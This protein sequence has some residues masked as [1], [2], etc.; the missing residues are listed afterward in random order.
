MAAILTSGTRIFNATQIYDSFNN[1]NVD[2]MYL[3]VGRSTPWA[4]DTTP[5]LPVDSFYEDTNLRRDILAMK[6]IQ[7]TDSSLGIFRRDWKLGTYYD[8]YRTD[9]GISG[10]NGVSPADGS[11]TTPESYL[12]ANYYVVTAEYNVYI[13]LWN[14]GGTISSVSPTGTSTSAFTT[15]DGYIWKYM[16]SISA[17]DV[18]KF[19]SSNFIPIK[20]ILTNPGAESSYYSQWE[21]QQA[22]V[23]GT[24]QRFL[25]TNGGSGYPV[26]TSFPIT[27]T[28]DGSGCVAVA[29]TN[30]SGS[31]SSITISNPGIGYTWVSVSIPSGIGAV[32]V[33]LLS[34]R[35]GFGSDPVVQLGGHFTLISTSIAFDEADFPQINDYRR[36]GIIR[37]P[38]NYGTTT[39]ANAATLSATKK[40]QLNLGVSGTFTL[41]EEITGTVSGAKGSVVSYDSTTKVLTYVQVG[42]Q[43][44]TFQVAESVTGAGSSAIGVISAVINAEVEVN[45]GEL[46]YL[47]HRRPVTRQADQTEY[48]KIT[49]ES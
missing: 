2:H 30:L 37:S 18:L 34:P 46:I 44:G 40:L 41:D 23:P 49:I 19:V 16:Y 28:G 6:R 1:E 15:A 22:A 38:W 39:I 45:S 32:V 17:A 13:C 3:F 33:P 10:V 29:N 36:I 27:V 12:D 35:G 7:E 9:Y 47:E 43:A 5:P 8:I 11:A 4:D 31:V 14:N 20:K 42:T 21:V 25:V 26:S 24:I 48:I